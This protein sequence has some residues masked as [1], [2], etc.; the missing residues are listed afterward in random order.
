MKRY[1]VFSLLFTFTVVAV[2]SAFH[3]AATPAAAQVNNRSH[4]RITSSVPAGGMNLDQVINNSIVVKITIEENGFP[5]DEDYGFMTLT[6]S[7]PPAYAWNCSECDDGFFSGSPVA[8]AT[9]GGCDSNDVKEWLVGTTVTIGGGVDPDAVDYTISSGSLGN[10]LRWVT[11]GPDCSDVVSP[12]TDT[13]FDTD[14]KVG[15]DQSTL[16]SNNGVAINLDYQ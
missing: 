2:L 10:G 5:N 13:Y 11:S 4:L 3:R 14:V 1:Q 7:D 6:P 15:W 8:C 9:L 12:V 16:C